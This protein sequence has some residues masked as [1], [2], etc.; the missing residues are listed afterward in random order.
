MRQ[1]Y[2]PEIH[3]AMVIAQVGQLVSNESSLLR[4]ARL[5]AR[6]AAV[7][8]T[9]H[10]AVL[11][12]DPSAAALFPLAVI[13][14]NKALPPDPF[15]ISA[16]GGLAGGGHTTTSLPRVRVQTEGLAL[17]AAAHQQPI[18]VQD[19]A[20]EARFRPAQAAP[21]AFVLGISPASICC[22]PCRER[23]RVV[24]VIV[25]AQPAPARGFTVQT[26]ELLNSL[27]ALVALTLATEERNEDA[28][29]LRFQFASAQEGDRRRLHTALLSGPIKEI[30]A[31]MQSVEQA[32]P[33][34]DHQPAEVRNQ[35]RALHTRLARIMQEL[36]GLFFEEH[37]VILEEDGLCSALQFLV[38]DTMR[39]DSLQVTLT[40]DI[41]SRLPLPV[42][43][44]AYVIVREGMMNALLHGHATHVQVLA[45]HNGSHL[46]LIIHDDGVGFDSHE[47]QSRY[48]TGQAGGLLHIY[49]RTQ[50]LGGKV[51]IDSRPGQGTVVDI[52]LPLSPTH[53]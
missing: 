4:R 47:V 39:T 21:D 2:M 5:L 12:Y 31:V 52:I 53:R 17:L 27:A 33:L 26:V 35:V 7:L 16:S 42:E 40:C 48:V 14:P 50:Q 38:D 10:A 30:A 37:P 18:L 32:D 51:A 13:D 15:S 28:A 6:A 3:Q 24:G 46:H 22:I 29:A 9:G 44:A 1:E 23:G 36:R 19:F 49:L 43:R 20:V 8:G 25:V 34:F 45:R 41:P 11:R